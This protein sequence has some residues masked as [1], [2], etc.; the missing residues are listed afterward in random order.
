MD[1]SKG[2]PSS[3]F[4]KFTTK[5]PTVYRPIFNSS[6]PGAIHAFARTCKAAHD[7][8]HE[9]RL[10]AFNINTHLQH[11]LPDPIEFR[12]MQARTGT[13][14]SGS[15]VVQ[16]MDR[17]RYDEADLDIYVNPG[18]TIAVGKHMVETQGY[19][20]IDPFVQDDP[21]VL[22]E[23]ES[24]QH[25][26]VVAIGAAEQVV[27]ARYKQRSIHIM[28]HMQ[29]VTQEGATQRAQVIVTSECVF[30]TVMNFHS[31][32][33]EFRKNQKM[34]IYDTSESDMHSADQAIEKY[35]GRDFE[36]L[37]YHG[38][39]IS[40]LLF[41]HG[42]DRKVGDR[43]CW[44]LHFDMAGVTPRHWVEDGP[45]EMEDGSERGSAVNS[46]ARRAQDPIM[47]NKWRMSGA[48]FMLSPKYCL[49]RLPIFRYGYAVADELEAM[50]AR[51]FSDDIALVKGKGGCDDRRWFDDDVATITEG[52]ISVC[53]EDWGLGDG[54]LGE[55]AIG[56]VEDE[57]GTEETD[58]QGYAAGAYPVK[59]TDLIPNDE[60]IFML[61]RYREAY[62]KDDEEGRQWQS[63]RD[64]RRR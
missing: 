16:F 25:M 58:D 62:E 26:T 38:A 9:Y 52:H 8:V 33:F 39:E 2:D 54:D 41:Q 27:K 5:Q 23:R 46:T 51:K 43:W 30:H 59:V 55:E 17:V 10:S 21:P 24:L 7:C 15:N 40:R 13:I 19:R 12:S 11:F 37:G 44:T 64:E 18:H 31:T 42:C 6:T 57:E 63:N 49:L 32:S 3:E 4:I 22:N 34:L 14:I 28:F 48:L 29:R 47:A 56:A 60:L 61:K 45:W 35:R 50:W 53:L 1:P 20:L 36:P